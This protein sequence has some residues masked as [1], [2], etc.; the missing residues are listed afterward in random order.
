MRQFGR[1]QIT[2]IQR[3]ARS[4]IVDYDGNDK[5]P[6]AK[7]KLQKWVRPVNMKWD[8]TENKYEV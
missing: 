1:T 4:F 7:I 3:D 5:T 6:F 8:M 2:P